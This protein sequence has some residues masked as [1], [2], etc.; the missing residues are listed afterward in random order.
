MAVWNLP[1]S[2]RLEAQ[3]LDRLAIGLVATNR[4]SILSNQLL[5]AA[6]QLSATNRPAPATNRPTVLT[7]AAGLLR[8]LLDDLFQQESYVE[9]RQATNQPGELVWAVRL[10]ADRARLWQ[11]NLAALIETLAGSRAVA[12]PTRSNGWQFRLTSQQPPVTRFVE[13]TR[14][15]EWTMISMGP[16]HNALATDLLNLIQT[17]GAPFARQPKEFWLYADLD[18]RR[19]ADALSL[20]WNLPADLPRMTVGINGDGQATRTRAQLDFPKPLTADLG[21]WTVPTNLIHDPLVSFT[22]IRGIGPWLDSLK[23]WQDFKVGSAPNQVYFW[24]ENGLPF[25]SFFAAPLPDASNRVAQVSARLVQQANPWLATNSQGRIERATNYNGVVWQD[26]PLMAPW[27]QSMLAG[28]GDLVCG[29]LVKDVSTNYPPPE[30]F[31]Q[32]T[33]PTNLV[34]YDWELTGTRVEQW[35]YFGQFFRLF[36]HKAQL[37]P[38]CAA[39]PWLE[40]LE[41]KLGNCVTAV[42]K[43]GPTQ[44]SLIRRS[45]VGL[46]SVEIQLLADWLESP[47]FPYGLRT[48][49]GPPESAQPK[50]PSHP[51]KAAPGPGVAHTNLPTRTNAPPGTK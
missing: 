35:L 22:A 16:E 10:N 36:L 1:E 6:S 15:G 33:A 14:A 12:T 46:N 23:L 45:T 38:K 5:L 4:A 42:S 32:F 34:A 8:S 31:L 17:N 7:G 39:I 2:K 20:P 30:L 9:V 28:A 50:K 27:L 47:Q 43:T 19:V 49:L 40:S 44:L 25:L 51:H 41:F 13:L 26:L 24:A 3:S 21:K 29:G 18:L 11:T 48:F 37:P